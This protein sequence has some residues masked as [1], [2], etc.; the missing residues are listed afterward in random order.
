MPAEGLSCV[1]S[2]KSSRRKD[3]ASGVERG[4]LSRPRLAR[5]EGPAGGLGLDWVGSLAAQMLQ[6]PLL[7]EGGRHAARAGYIWGVKNT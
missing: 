3:G 6:A 5:G 2:R 4:R 1:P 7:R